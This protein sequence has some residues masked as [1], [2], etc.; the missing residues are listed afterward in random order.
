[1]ALQWNL[2]RYIDNKGENEAYNNLIQLVPPGKRSDFNEMRHSFID[3]SKKSLIRTRNGKELPADLLSL[4]EKGELDRAVIYILNSGGLL[5]QWQG[6]HKEHLRLLLPVYYILLEW[7]YPKENSELN[8]PI[9]TFKEVKHN[10]PE[11]LGWENLPKLAEIAQQDRKRR[12]GLVLGCVDLA[13]SCQSSIG[14][15]GI[16]SN[17]LPWLSLLKLWF[18]TTETP[19]SLRKQILLAMIISY[20]KYLLLHAYDETKGKH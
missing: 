19:A 18:Y 11:L 14:W 20:L 6:A 4:Y 17:Y 3:T 1:M 9:S 16:R 7:D 8:K 12:K 10:L 13:L 2:R 15:R 5:P